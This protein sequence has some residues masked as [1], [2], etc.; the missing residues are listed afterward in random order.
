MADPRNFDVFISY[1]TKDKNWALKFANELE[2]NGVHAWI[3]QTEIKLGDRVNEKLEEAL[4]ESKVIAVL[5]TP[6]YLANP[7][8]AFEL[9]AAVGGNKKII[10]I[11]PQDIEQRTMPSL[12][13]GRQLLQESSP[14]AAGKAVAAVV[15]GLAP[16]LSG[17]FAG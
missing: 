11:I 16:G 5:V 3:D 4:R 13:R 2:A 10:P 8:S 12:L 15:G 6:D 14:Q 1:S 17:K 7:S 9:G